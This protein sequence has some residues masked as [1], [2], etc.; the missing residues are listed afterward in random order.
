[1]YPYKRIPSALFD[2]IPEGWSFGHSENGW[3]ISESFYEYMANVFLPWC[4][5]MSIEFPILMYLDGHSSHLS[6]SLSEFCSEH[7][8][9]MINLYPNSTHVS[10]PMDVAMFHSV[11]T[12][13]KSE[14]T[15]HRI[16]NNGSSVQRVDFAPV[17]KKTLEKVDVSKNL[18]SGFKKC[19][20]YPFN[21]NALDYS[22]LFKVVEEEVPPVVSAVFDPVVSSVLEY[23]EN[24]LDQNLKQLFSMTEQAGSDWAGEEQYKQLFMLWLNCRKT[25]K[26]NTSNEESPQVN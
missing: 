18:V 19:G 20:L 26:S 23:V 10:Q 3:M 4:I 5:K 25:V 21:P 1:M 12:E 7:K 14:T 24:S 8:I 9:E 2:K 11:K 6:L 15:N 17:L 16:D 22:K 13:W